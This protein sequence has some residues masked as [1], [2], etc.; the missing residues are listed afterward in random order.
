MSNLTTFISMERLK[1][2]EFGFDQNIDQNY[3]IPNIIK[4]Q[5]FL[6]KPLLGDI[7]YNEMLTYVESLKTGGTINQ[8]YDMLI[9]DYI[10]PAIAYYVKSEMVFNTAYKIKNTPQDSNVDRFNELVNISKKYLAD[11]DSF[12]NMLREYMCENNIPQDEPVNYKSCGVY[13]GKSVNYS[14]Y[15]QNNKPNK[16]Y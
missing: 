11:S 14:K 3:I 13:L 9:D 16:N 5:K 1:S 7:K 10:S 12:L 4:G 15:L 6:I 2:V 8:D